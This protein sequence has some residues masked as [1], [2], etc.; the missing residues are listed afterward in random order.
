MKRHH[1]LLLWCGVVVLCV[2]SLV[3]VVVMQS[4]AEAPEKGQLDSLC[5]AIGTGCFTLERVTTDQTRQ[6][7]LSDRLQLA[8]DSGMLF[9]F[10]KPAGYC[11]WMKDMK[12]SID[13]IWLND[14]K[15]VVKVESNVSPETYPK[16]FCP[17][18][19]SRYVIELN[20]GQADKVGLST[21]T[22]LN[23]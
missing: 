10:E 16:S 4:K 2:V 15:E 8:D 14:A 19:P 12:F 9:V 22:K 3:L 1:K 21:G 7:G 23:F 5:T 18:T 17:E 6:K 11:F 20:A 13:M